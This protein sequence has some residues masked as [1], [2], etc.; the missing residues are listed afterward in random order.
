MNE[1]RFWRSTLALLALALAIL[2]LAHVWTVL[3][4]FIFGIIIAYLV[5]PLVDGMASLGLKRG[6]VVLILYLLLLGVGIFLAMSLIPALVREM[7]QAVVEVP[8]Y[9]S[10]LDGLIASI[11]VEIQK[12]LTPVLKSRAKIIVIPFAAQKFLESLVLQLPQNV[13]SVA[14]VG[15]WI[16]VIPFMSF[17]ALSHGKRWMDL[18]FDITPSEYVEGLLGIIAELNATLGGYVRGVIIES[19]CIGLLTIIGLLI[20]GVKGA[21]LI[22]FVTGLV[23]FVPFMAPLIGGGLAL[24]T[25]YFQFKSLSV[26]F[27]IALLFISLRLFDDFVLIPFVVGS[28][29]HLHP[30]VMVFAVL[31]GVELG[32]FLGLVFA[33]PVAVIIKV[34]LSVALQHRKEQL[35]FRQQ[36][37]YS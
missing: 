28:S 25:A 8:S 11:N 37:V 16:I 12:L 27:G 24:L 4:P 36:H 5:N 21:V 32:G 23:N 6:R 33:I 9:A 20:M 29:V 3:L 17:F 15:L 18:I 10:A 1:T 13:L 19:F 30:V 34:F 31:A 14:H 22:G 2:F 35:M 7:N 26:L